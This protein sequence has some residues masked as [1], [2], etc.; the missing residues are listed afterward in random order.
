[1]IRSTSPPARSPMSEDVL[2]VRDIYE[3]WRTDPSFTLAK[4]RAKYLELFGISHNH[5]RINDEYISQ[6]LT[7][8]GYARLFSWTGP[9]VA[10]PVKI[11]LAL[12]L[13]ELG[14]RKRKTATFGEIAQME[15]ARRLKAEL[16]KKSTM[17]KS[18]AYD[19]EV[20]AAEVVSRGFMWRGRKRRFLTKT[21]I[22]E[23]FKN[24]GRYGLPGARDQIK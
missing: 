6:V 12:F 23:R 13:R 16:K 22:L 7:Q 10:I 17:K 24:P 3:R 2:K 9:D 18:R 19:A 21:Q 14:G 8:F 4:A 15:E 5:K 20:A 11:A 1:V